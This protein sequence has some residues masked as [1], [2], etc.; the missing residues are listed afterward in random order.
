[1]RIQNP[2]LSSWLPF[3][4]KCCEEKYRRQDFPQYTK[5]VGTDQEML[6]QLVRVSHP[7]PRTDTVTPGKIQQLA[8]RM[9]YGLGSCDK[10]LR[11]V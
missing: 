4:V 2:T 5:A 1:V 10:G 6:G 7:L 11:T 8:V 3:C 9:L